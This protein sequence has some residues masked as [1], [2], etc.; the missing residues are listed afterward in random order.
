MQPVEPS[1]FAIEARVYAENPARDY[2]PSPGT[3]QLVDWKESASSRIDTSVRTGTVVSA[4]YDRLLAK[5][6][7]HSPS[8]HGAIRGMHD[9]LTIKNVDFLTAVLEDESFVEGNTMTKFLA[10]FSYSPSA[11]DVV[12]AGA[13]TTVRD[14]PGRPS[15]GRCFPHA[16]PMDLW[17]SR[18][19]IYSST[20]S[21][22]PRGRSLSAPMEIKI[23]GTPS[24][25]WTRLH[26][27]A[28][29]KLK[30]LP[31]YSW[32][33]SLGSER[34]GSKA[35]SPG[36]SVG[37]YQGRALVG[38][39]VLGTTKSI[40]NSLSSAIS[41]PERLIPEY[42]DHWDLMTMIGPYADG[43]L[44]EEDVKM[45]YDTKWQVFHNAA[46]GGVR[47]I[48][49]KPKWAR[50]DGDEGGSHPFNVPEYGYPVG[51]L[52]WTGDDP[53]IFPVNCPDFGGFVSST[54]II[55]ADHGR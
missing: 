38:G 54:T 52:N 7:Y 35:T 26:M 13:Y 23:D 29:Q 8:R 49:P 28:G 18:L 37:G 30:L 12:S 3:L 51:T 39:E 9:S 45:M 41:L 15:M 14:Y 22:A 47:L 10:H 20:T 19:R 46:P 24:S 48:G 53:C 32:W 55:K 50:A 5:V 16:G 2:A 11:I 33:S 1:G 27:K 42:P 4:S 25:M 31:S 21:M 40:P 6:M 34:F 17:H 36:I 44:L 43:Y